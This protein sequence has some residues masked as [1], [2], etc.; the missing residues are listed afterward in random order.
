MGEGFGFTYAEAMSCKKPC[1]AT[2]FG[3]QKD[4]INT[5][6]G[7]L[8][9]CKLIDSYE[10]E[11]VKW[12][13]PDV[14]HLKKL[15]RACFK[16]KKKAIEKGEQAYKDISKYSWRNSVKKGMKFLKEL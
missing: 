9:D 8:L 14:E 10:E 15:M 7:W 3:G 16:Y 2:N 13:L 12:A 11:G 1:I 4:F 6:N 5:K